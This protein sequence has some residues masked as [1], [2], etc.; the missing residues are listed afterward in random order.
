MQTPWTW[1]LCLPRAATLQPSTQRGHPTVWGPSG[2]LPCGATFAN[3]GGLSGDALICHT[4]RYTRCKGAPECCFHKINYVFF[5]PSRRD[6][7]AELQVLPT[8]TIEAGGD[9]GENKAVPTTGFGKHGPALAKLPAESQCIFSTM[10][11]TLKTETEPVPR[12]PAT[13]SWHGR[14]AGPREKPNCH[15]VRYCENGNHFCFVQ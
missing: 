13:S 9:S 1:C 15:V 3:V 8:W 4:H 12:L 11:K 10:K 14:S 6:T 5:F 7:V 2:T